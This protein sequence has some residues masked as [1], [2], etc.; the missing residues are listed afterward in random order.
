MN[1]WSGNW[2][3]LGRAVGLGYVETGEPGK[4][5]PEWLMAGTYELEIA[6]ERFAA[7]PTLKPPYDPTGARIRT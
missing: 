2:H 5:T 4:C 3:T 7:T 1:R 6:T